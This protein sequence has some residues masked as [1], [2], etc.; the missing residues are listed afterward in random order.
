[1]T[2]R[3]VISFSFIF[4]SFSHGLS[5]VLGHSAMKAKDTRKNSCHVLLSSMPRATCRHV[6]ASYLF[7]INTDFCTVILGVS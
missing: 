1:M 2:C 4:C 5:S 3:L 7:F 6:T